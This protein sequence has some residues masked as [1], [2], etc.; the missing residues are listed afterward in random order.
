M[1]SRLGLVSRQPDIK[2]SQ[3]ASP[4]RQMSLPTAP[5][6]EPSPDVTLPWL[7]SPNWS[8]SEL[9]LSRKLLTKPP[10]EALTEISNL[11]ILLQSQFY[12][13]SLRFKDGEPAMT[14]SYAETQHY[15]MKL[16]GL[17]DE[18]GALKISGKD[19]AHKRRLA[20]EIRGAVASV[21]AWI[22]QEKVKAQKFEERVQLL[23]A[24][25]ERTQE[26]QPEPSGCLIA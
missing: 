15:T 13:P 25:E 11:Y 12:Y 3:Y 10:K 17:L 24:Q 22:E 14:E 20:N 4:N 19:E 7:L 5:E 16:E 6:D 8:P 23:L 1:L 26:N 2:V 18:L 21:K 9:A